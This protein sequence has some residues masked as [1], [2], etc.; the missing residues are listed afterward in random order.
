VHPYRWAWD[1][2]ALVL[3]PGLCLAYAAGIQGH[4]TARWRLASFVAGQALILAAFVTPLETLALHYLLTAHLL[5]NVVLAEWAPALCVLG[6]PPTLAASLGRVGL[7]RTLTRP[8]VALPL[9]L[10]VYFV[11]HLPPLYDTALRHPESLL[12][13]EHV[14]YF[15]AGCLL[16]WP[17]FHASP[18]HVSSGGKAGYLVAGFLLASP[19]GLLFALIPDAVYSFYKAAPRLW[20]LSALE[21]QQIAGITMAGE[22]A[23]VFFGAFLVYLLRFLGEEEARDEG[24]HARAP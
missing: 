5:Q 8:L 6:V 18:W 1:L 15:A 24:A 23:F 19:L 7:I 21:D 12:H 9:W 3:V 2:E 14:C 16:W 22:E 11:W 20:G 17:V 4:V 13:L 10:A